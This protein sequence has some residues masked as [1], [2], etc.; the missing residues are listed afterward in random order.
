MHNKK[1]AQ[2]RIAY[3]KYSIYAFIRI[4]FY[5]YLCMYVPYLFDLKLIVE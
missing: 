3:L 2:K 5:F 1:G 4:D